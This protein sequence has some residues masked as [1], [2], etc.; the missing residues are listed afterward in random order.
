MGADPRPATF[1][2]LLLSAQV[3]ER[4]A[5]RYTPA[6][7]PALDLVL[8]HEGQ[9]SE[10]GQPRLVRM[11]LKAVAIGQISR[12]AEQLALGEPRQFAGFL[13]P[14]RGGKGLIFH[15]NEIA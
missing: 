8:A 15:I 2:R 12:S 14:S 1:N 7:L 5:R 6:G 3:Q 13:A 9:A 10:D 4:S 11:H